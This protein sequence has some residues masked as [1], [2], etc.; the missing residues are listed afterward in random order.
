M[1]LHPHLR[2]AF[3]TL[4]WFPV[5]FT[6][7]DHVYQPCL[8]SGSSMAPT[9]NPATKT[10]QNDVV[11]IQKYNLKAPNSLKRGDVIM[12]HSPS[13]PEKLVTKRVVGL[14]GDVIIPRN[15][16]YPRNQALIPR[17]HLWVEGDNAFHSIDSNDF[18][19]I[20]QALVVG[21]VVSVIWPF[22]RIATDIT[23]GGR[24]GRKK[25]VPLIDDL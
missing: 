13:D 3:F 7:L 15:K 14:Q 24:D 5:F 25:D 4:T 19:P 10:T 8:I 17:N 20:S 6:A 18:G 16:A 1:S 23:S 21:K 11:L 9:F 12:F 2:T 22:S